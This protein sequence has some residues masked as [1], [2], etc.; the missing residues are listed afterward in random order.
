M[1]KTLR[2]LTLILACLFG[3]VLAVQADNEKP[4]S[5]NQLPKAAQQT[6]SKHF[7]GLKVALA[8]V[9]SGLLEKSYDVVFTNGDHLEFDRNGGWTEISSKTR[10]VP[11]ALIPTGISTYLKSNYPG[12]KVVQIE[13]DRREYEVELANGVEVTFNMSFQVVDIDF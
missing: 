4:I 8:K 10:G 9:E 2:N 11:S 6:V 12:Q 3:T 5:V 1:K 7:S 13:R